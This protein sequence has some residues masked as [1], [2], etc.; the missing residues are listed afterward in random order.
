MATSNGTGAE[1]ETLVGLQ[2]DSVMRILRVS[3][4]PFLMY[5]GFEIGWL[6]G[7]RNLPRVSHHKL[8]LVSRF[9]WLRTL[10]RREAQLLTEQSCQMN[11]KSYL[12]NTVHAPELWA[13]LEYL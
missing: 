7:W 1:T 12:S 5:R 10:G 3:C 6:S 2:G 9:C 11:N 4:Y 13:E 8:G